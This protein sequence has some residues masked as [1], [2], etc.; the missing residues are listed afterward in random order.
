M[1]TKTQRLFFCCRQQNMDSSMFIQRFTFLGGDFELNPG[2]KQCSSNGFSNRHWNLDSVSAHNYTKII[3]LK[4]K[5]A[6]H[7]FDIVCIPETYLDSN[8]SP[9]DNNLYFPVINFIRSDNPSSNKR[10]GICINYKHFVP[11][12]IPNIQYLQEWVSG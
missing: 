2:P 8:I 10:E 5:I 12:R 11:L 6:I 3:F 7:K 9:D 1:G 4:A